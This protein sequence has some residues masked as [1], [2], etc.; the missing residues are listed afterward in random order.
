MSALCQK[1]T[2]LSGTQRHLTPRSPS[3]AKSSGRLL[4]PTQLLLEAEAVIPVALIDDLAVLDPHEGH[5]VELN[6]LPVAGVSGPH[7]PVLVP[8]K[9]NSH[10]MP[11]AL[12]SARPSPSKLDQ[13]RRH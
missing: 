6:G 5:S 7:A 12:R 10:A 3:V 4:N 1:Q 8:A 9:V 2:F 13:R 11:F